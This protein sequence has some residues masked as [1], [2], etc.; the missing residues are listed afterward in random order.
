MKAK[1]AVLL[2]MLLVGA[3]CKSTSP[4][5]DARNPDSE[6]AIRVESAANGYSVQ[7]MR[8]RKTGVCFV[9]VWN[10][11]TVVVPSE[12]CASGESR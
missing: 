2:G 9:S 4:D 12:V 8:H 6:W 7:I 11:G 5:I 3:G 1:C 10:A